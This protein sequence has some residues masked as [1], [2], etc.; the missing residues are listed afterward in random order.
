[1][2]QGEALDKAES[3]L[4]SGALQSATTLARAVL[5]AE[6]RQS[7]ALRLLAAIGEAEERFDDA[8]RLFGEAIEADPND[9]SAVDGLIRIFHRRGD[10]D[11]LIETLL[12]RL[13]LEPG[14][15]AYWNDLGAV[16][17][18]HGQLE[19]GRCAYARAISILP[20]LTPAIV[21]VAAASFRQGNY[22]S[23]MQFS[24]RAIALDP[25]AGR[26]HLIRG[27][28][29]QSLRN[30]ASSGP[31]YRTAL[32]IDPGDPSAWQ[33][34]TAV[35]RS[36][37]NHQLV[38]T[39]AS[40]AAYIALNDPTA[41][42]NLAEALRTIGSP[43]EACRHSR[44]S[45]VCSPSLALAHNALALSCTDQGADVDALTAARR[46]L[47]CD[48]GRADLKI[49][50]GV[51]L[52]AIGCLRAAEHEIRSGL[53]RQPD[54]PGAHMS[55]ATTLLAM[56]QVEEGLREY[57]W[58]HINQASHYDKFPAPRWTGQK[59]LNGTLLVWGEQG[60]GDEIMFSQHLRD[61]AKLA[62]HMIVEC[63]PRMKSIFE[64]SYP[65]IEFIPKTT[66]SSPRLVEADVC[67]QIALCSLPLALGLTRS[68]IRSKSPFLVPDAARRDAMRA[69]LAAYGDMPKVGIAWRS[70]KDTPA[71][72]RHHTRLKEWE[73]VLRT[74][75]VK[76]VSLQYR[77]PDDEIDAVRRSLGIEIAPFSD[78]DMFNDLEGALAL[79][80]GLDLVLATATTAYMLASAAGTTVW[81]MMSKINY[82]TFGYAA[83]PLSPFIRGYPRQPGA[84]WSEPINL[85]AQ[86]LSHWAKLDHAGRQRFQDQSADR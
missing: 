8:A 55:L 58:R 15:A 32:S 22:A 40:R 71:M 49:N 83:D 56:G 12:L 26:A 76:F 38:L 13:R 35:A 51:A 28:A 23:A 11:R 67:A 84:P 73:R 64:R 29:S 82:R 60:V 41:L 36:E 85:I 62:P 59:L 39:I 14:N 75:N 17:E 68:S 77:D 86:D 78:I 45:V 69:R 43:A 72:R 53:L 63:D 81:Q 5:H 19:S 16:L 3:F 27:H 46:A 24:G 74:P 31:A 25:Y 7:R 2:K 52:K 79:G 34:L 61:A 54:D 70:L 50:L 4:R 10:I 6:P 44:R 65:G 1:M 66:P 9:L 33:G 21:N 20:N 30:L 57:E 37:G 47:V 18:Q 48:P 80:A 42:A